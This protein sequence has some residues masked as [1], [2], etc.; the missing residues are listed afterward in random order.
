MH[1]APCHIQIKIRPYS[2]F[3]DSEYI[4]DALDDCMYVPLMLF[5]DSHFEDEDIYID[6]VETIDGY[7]TICFDGLC[8]YFRRYMTGYPNMR[9]V[10]TIDSAK[11]WALNFSKYFGRAFRALHC[12]SLLVAMPLEPQGVPSCELGIMY[13]SKDEERGYYSIPMEEVPKRFLKSRYRT[14]PP[15]PYGAMDLEF[16]GWWMDLNMEARCKALNHA[17]FLPIPKATRKK[18]WTLYAD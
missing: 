13:Q 11:T 17:D 6:K 18:D 3:L 12:Q 9:Y 10:Y 4:K 14:G 15:K 5:P 8:A 16:A 1:Y 7:K 2:K